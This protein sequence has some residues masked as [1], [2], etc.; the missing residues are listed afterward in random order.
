MKERQVDCLKGLEGGGRF[1]SRKAGIKWQ[2]EKSVV[3]MV[4]ELSLEGQTHIH[5]GKVS[6]D[7]VLLMAVKMRLRQVLR[8]EEHR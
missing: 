1:L 5:R 3:K 2:P 6:H 4:S 7:Q 8:R